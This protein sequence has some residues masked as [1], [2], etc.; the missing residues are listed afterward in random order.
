[1]TI[2]KQDLLH[3]V[4]VKAPHRSHLIVT[5]IVYQDVEL[6]VEVV[7]NQI[8]QA[9]GSLKRQDISWYPDEPWDRSLM[10][11]ITVSNIGLERL[12][13]V[14]G[15]LRGAC[16]D[17]VSSPPGEIKSDSSTNAS[18]RSTVKRLISSC[19]VLRVTQM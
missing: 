12:E 9:F 5:G 7:L 8:R 16:P 19:R 18:G 17:D 14:Q 3:K 6:S 15:S 1:M 2:S 11:T 10:V 13:K 4:I